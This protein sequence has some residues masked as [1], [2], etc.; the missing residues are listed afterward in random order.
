ML[1]QLKDKHVATINVKKIACISKVH[2]E[3]KK[4]G[5]RK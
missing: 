1:I 3:E 5:A 4:Y 2:F